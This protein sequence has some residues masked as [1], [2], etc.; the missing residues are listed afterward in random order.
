M[1]GGEGR[2]GEEGRLEGGAGRGKYHTLLQTADLTGGCLKLGPSFV[3]F[4][5]VGEGA[6]FHTL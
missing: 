4:I 1:E 6:K 2:W 5:R 3:N